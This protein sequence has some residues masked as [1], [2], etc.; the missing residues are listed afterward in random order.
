MASSRLVSNRGAE[1]LGMARNDVPDEGQRIHAY[2]NI[3]KDTVSVRNTSRKV[4]LHRP[5]VVLKEADFRVSEAGRERVLKEEWRNVHAV[6]YGYWSSGC[7]ED[8]PVEVRYNPYEDPYFKTVEGG[9]PVREAPWVVIEKNR[10][11]IP[12]GSA[13]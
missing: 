9:E 11:Y 5:S 4:I 2:Y 13:G 12:R 7:P 8:C 1:R 6:V 3:P 10:C